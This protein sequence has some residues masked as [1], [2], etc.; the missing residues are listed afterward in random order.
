MTNRPRMLLAAIATGLLLA[1]Q[2][3]AIEP[4]RT[5]I[6][7]PR[8]AASLP[9]A[10]AA[11]GMVGHPRMDGVLGRLTVAPPAA[12]NPAVPTPRPHGLARLHGLGDG[13]ELPVSRIAAPTRSIPNAVSTARMMALPPMIRRAPATTQ[14]G[15][16]TWYGGRFHGRRTASGEVFDRNGLTAAHRTLPFGTRVRVTNTRNGKFVDVRVNDRGPHSR[17]L[18]I[19]LSQEA[20]RRIGVT[21]SGEVRMEV[22]DPASSA[23]LREVA[24][25]D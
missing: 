17:R 14:V 7:K 16:A 3:W 1:G 12:G 22:L 2:A 19:D 13:R 4:V 6:P 9:G 18:M 25:R 24:T 21:G 20:A 8:P 10:H 11:S 5:P 15:I 23:T